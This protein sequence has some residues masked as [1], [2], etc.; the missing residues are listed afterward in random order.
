MATAWSTTITD[1]QRRDYDKDGVVRTE[2]EAQS[3]S[4]GAT[5]AVGQL[6]ALP[7]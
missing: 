7:F 3:Q 5:P 2:T 4:T 1:G 6:I